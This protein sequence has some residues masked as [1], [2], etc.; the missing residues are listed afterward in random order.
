MGNHLS[1]LD[2]Q[3]HHISAAA[4][5]LL[6]RLQNLRDTVSAIISTKGTCFHRNMHYKPHTTKSG[7]YGLR[8]KISGHGTPTVG[9]V[10][11]DCDI[12]RL[13]KLNLTYLKTVAASRR[14][15]FATMTSKI[16]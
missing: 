15:F 8:V 11:Y 4:W 16:L 3:E 9:T 13:S 5:P 2:G 10:N 12:P 1:P 6:A 7:K 14:L